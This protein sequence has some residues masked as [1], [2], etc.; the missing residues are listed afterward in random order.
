MARTKQPI[1][2]NYDPVT[3]RL[4]LAEGDDKDDSPYG[5]DG[6]P[7]PADPTGPV[8][9]KLTKTPKKKKSKKA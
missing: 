5:E 4:K 1:T 9:W 3:K 2:Y 6:I 7:D 8:K